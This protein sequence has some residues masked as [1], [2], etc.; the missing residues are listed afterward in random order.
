MN[1]KLSTGY[2]ILIIFLSTNLLMSC[3]P[4]ENTNQAS[5][6]QLKIDSIR[7]AKDI[8]FGNPGSS[9]FD[10][11][12]AIDTFEGLHYF[13][14]DTTYRVAAKFEKLEDDS[15]FMMS[16]SGDIADPYKRFARLSMSVKGHPVQLTA[17]QN[18]RLL[19]NDAYKNYL[20]IPFK[21]LNSGK[22]TYGGGRY[23]DIDIP[24]AD[25]VIIDF[26]AAYNPYC[27]YSTKWSC[28]IPPEEN[29]LK[30]AI[31]AGEK[32]YHK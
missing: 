19:N 28:P 15:I 32:N 16:T 25:T 13:A 30:I 20:F 17:Y 27:A 4:A 29:C 9:P 24:D 6:W 7:K 1:R 2:A 8:E 23:L 11:Q 21:D 26:N 10:N 31:N 3:H 12:A 5:Q 22:S 18:Q 14:T